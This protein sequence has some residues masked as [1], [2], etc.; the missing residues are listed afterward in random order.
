MKLEDLRA[1]K[2]EL[3]THI[4]ALA[5]QWQAAQGN[6]AEV[7]YWITQAEKAEAELAP[8]SETVVE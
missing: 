1:R 6:L 2:A 5:G 8:D 3:D 7:N 4:L